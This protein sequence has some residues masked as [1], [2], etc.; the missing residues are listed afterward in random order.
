MADFLQSIRRI[1][2]GLKKERFHREE[3]G[4]GLGYMQN[5]RGSIRLY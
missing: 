5:E 1:S 2:F 4:G 3:G